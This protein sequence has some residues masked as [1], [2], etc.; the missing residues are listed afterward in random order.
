MRFILKPFFFYIYLQIKVTKL[1]SYEENY[2]IRANLIRNKELLYLRQELAVWALTLV[3]TITSPVVAT[4]ATFAVYVLLSNDN[5]ILTAS[6]TFTVLLLFSVLRFPI[7]LAGRFLGSKFLFIIF[8]NDDI[9]SIV[10]L[11][12]NNH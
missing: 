7:N 10:S 8:I 9:S 6:Q 1:N 5:N 11:K 3:L 4:G 2:K 12:A